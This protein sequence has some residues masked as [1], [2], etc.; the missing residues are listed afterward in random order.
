MAHHLCLMVQIDP[1]GNGL[2]LEFGLLECSANIAAVEQCVS[3]NMYLYDCDNAEKL[4]CTLVVMFE[5]V[6]MGMIASIEELQL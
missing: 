4:T 6:L 5:E 2:T 3:A 1:Q